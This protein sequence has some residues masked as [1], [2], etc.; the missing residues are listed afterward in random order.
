MIKVK[1]ID[2]DNFGPA[3]KKHLQEKWVE[4]MTCVNY[5]GLGVAESEPLIQETRKVPLYPISWG[6]NADG[7]AG[8][9]TMREI[10]KPQTVHRSTMRNYISSSAG[11]HHSLLVSDTG[12]VY[13]F[14]SGRRGQLGYFPNEFKGQLGGKVKGPKG[15]I[16]QTLPRAVIGTGTLVFGTDLKIGQVC[17]GRFSSVARQISTQEGIGSI[18]T[19]MDT[20]QYLEDLM[21]YYSD[22]VDLQKAWALCRHE[23]YKVMA[24][25][26][27]QLTSWGKGENGELGL[28][29]Y[30]KFNPSPAV[31]PRLR[32]TVVVQVAMGSH[33]ALAVDHEK[34]LYTWGSGAFGKLG[35]GDFY[36]RYSPTVVEFFD[37]YNVEFV[38]AGDNHSAC[39][40]TTRKSEGTKKVDQLKR[41][42][43]WG[44]GAH[45]RLGYGRNYLSKVPKLVDEWPP[46]MAGCQ[47]VSLACGGAHTLVLGY[48]LVE[49]C[50]VFSKGI[51]TFLC[52]WGYGTNGQLGNGYTEDSFLP[53]RVRFQAKSELIV[54]IAAG[55][56]WSMARSYKGELWTWGKGLRGQLGQGKAKFSVVPRKVDT[57]TSFLKIDSGFGHSTCLSTSKKIF[58][59]VVAESTNEGKDVFESLV[60]LTLRKRESESLYEFDCCCGTIHPQRAKL[61]YI[62]KTCNIHSVCVGCKTLCHAK[63]Q[64]VERLDQTEEEMRALAKK[65]KK[66]KKAKIKLKKGKKADP[67]K[68]RAAEKLTTITL[69]KMLK[70]SGKKVHEH[71]DLME[72]KLLVSRK[73]YEKDMEAFKQRKVPYCACSMHHPY[74]RRIPSI[75]EEEVSI[76]DEYGDSQAI[77]PKIEAVRGERAIDLSTLDSAMRREQAAMRIQ[78]QAQWYINRRHLK[79]I[80]Q[81][82]G[83]L[84]YEAS[85]MH[86]EENI[87]GPIWKKLDRARSAFREIRETQ[88]MLIE[89]VNKHKYDYSRD[90]QRA[91]GVSNS[92]M[93]GIEKVIGKMSPQL[94]TVKYGKIR[95]RVPPNPSFAWTVASIREQQLKLHPS[96]RLSNAQFVEL[97]QHLPRGSRGDGRIKSDPDLWLYFERYMQDLRT[98]QW[99]DHY[100]WVIAEKKRIRE[101]AVAAARKILMKQRFGAAQA[102]EDARRLQEEKAG[103]KKP[104][105]P[106]AGPPPEE[107][108]RLKE[109]SEDEE[110]DHSKPPADEDGSDLD[111]MRERGSRPDTA[112]SE[113]DEVAGEDASKF[114]V[115]GEVKQTHNLIR[116][117]HS[118][119]A[120]Q[121]MFCRIV[122]EAPQKLSFQ[123]AI[124]RRNSL[125]ARMSE[126]YVP[127]KADREGFQDITDSLELFAL[128]LKQIGDYSDPQFAHVWDIMEPK[129]RNKRTKRLL[130]YSY[131]NPRLPLEMRRI[132]T[133]GGRRRTIGEPERLAKQSHMM[134]E[135]RNW[136]VKGRD[137]ASSK[138]KMTFRRRSFDLGEWCDEKSGILEILGYPTDPHQ[139]WRAPTMSDTRRDSALMEN[140]MIFAG[141]L[142]ADETKRDEGPDFSGFEAKAVV[143]QKLEEAPFDNRVHEQKKNMAK[144]HWAASG[145]PKNANAGA[146]ERKF[147]GEAVILWQEFF[148]ESGETYYYNPKTQ[149][150]S[151]EYPQ[152]PGVQV[153]S[154][155]QDDDGNFY[156]YNFVTGESEWA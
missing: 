135:Q 28:G 124:K 33:H 11:T 76:L 20:K 139:D 118:I 39:L 88:E 95:K 104:P 50:L 143:E 55:R 97:T 79:K 121:G 99:R 62:C 144:G 83:E 109:E 100:N 14:G 53:M 141:V 133:N 71:V 13:S 94:P 10:R 56:S 77:V 54:E 119:V 68:T 48:R 153:V 22:S 32:R 25:S 87:L 6:W 152:G 21:H 102:I 45:G 72:V 106:P 52:A 98:V 46:S 41:V 107:Q 132:L 58:R 4:D 140:R 151:W 19:L 127:E 70:A 44:K 84:R 147:D 155:Y 27:G 111:E 103:M 96:Q 26:H 61:R 15:G 66:K 126:L 51:Q 101:A 125:P 59:E 156:W 80:K 37:R 108:V 3:P 64:V 35:H 142:K 17:A 128:R 69:R 65:K 131:F 130:G 89:D 31:I 18:K 117:R 63:C 30:V 90:L 82:I 86:W 134:L 1:H 122:N 9:A 145:K 34:R 149:E 105:A 150:S 78:R 91:V 110:D 93:F 5:K 7:R 74:C 112:A 113:I 81:K 114:D 154:Q 148:S 67:A 123:G 38:A 16:Q 120:P 12:V 138:Q 36:N 73:R 92:I 42:S 43:C 49:K 137:K 8:N 60:P 29:R 47:F 146:A 85:V 129:P 115:H 75:L 23:I 136:F 40:T 2:T 24:I 116:R 57:F